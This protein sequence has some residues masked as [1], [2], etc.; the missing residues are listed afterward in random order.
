MTTNTKR[1][2]LVQQNDTHSYMELRTGLHAIDALRKHFK[3]HSPVNA[4]LTHA[5][6]VAV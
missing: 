1:L 3:R 5:K 2:T 6:F 4:D